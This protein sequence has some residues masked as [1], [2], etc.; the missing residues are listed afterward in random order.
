MTYRCFN[1]QHTGN[2]PVCASLTVLFKSDNFFSRSARRERAMEKSSQQD[3]LYMQN[4]RASIFCWCQFSQFK[5]IIESS[6]THKVFRLIL[7]RWILTNSLEW[8]ELC[9]LVLLLEL[10]RQCACHHTCTYKGV[11]TS[12]ANIKAARPAPPLFQG[13]PQTAPLM[14]A[15]CTGSLVCFDHN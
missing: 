7:A 5:Q 11:M 3:D 12:Y 9:S 15:A 2:V 10:T 8:L 6:Q 14:R 4:L 1:S 13:N